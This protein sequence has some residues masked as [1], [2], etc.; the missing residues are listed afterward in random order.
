MHKLDR[1]IPPS[2][3]SHYL[4]GRDK[5]GNVTTNHKTEIWHKLDEMQQHL[6]AY[7]EIEIKTNKADSN[8]HI[9]H[10]R[11]R[12]VGAYPHGAF[13]WSNIFGSCNR[14][15]S[16]GKHKDSLPPYNHLNLIKM[17]TDDPELFLEF[18]VDGNVVPAKGLSSSDRHRAEETIRI[19]NLNGSL[20]KIRETAVKGYMQTAEE[21]ADYASEFDEEDWFPLLQD[22][23]DQIDGLPFTTAIKHVLLPK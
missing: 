17:D 9:E 14:Q 16:C 11:Q 7:C 20:R 15:D 6:C 12:R 3:L 2:C 5:W 8:S 23:L 4:Y 19:F 18:L 1:P 10:F 22:E 13:M 21:L